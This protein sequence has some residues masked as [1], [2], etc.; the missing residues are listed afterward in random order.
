MQDASST[1]TKEKFP[2]IVCTSNLSHA[3]FAVSAFG[4]VVT[5]SELIDGRAK[6][7]LKL[8]PDISFTEILEDYSAGGMVVGK[9]Y[10]AAFQSLKGVVRKLLVD[11]E[12][13]PHREVRP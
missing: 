13:R 5:G 9:D 3:A 1:P 12:K 6:F 11:S 8:S 10:S 2:E 7:Y 4:A